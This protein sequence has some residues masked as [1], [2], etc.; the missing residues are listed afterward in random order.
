MFLWSEFLIGLERLFARHLVM[1][2]L[3]N[4]FPRNGEARLSVYI[5]RLIKQVL[6]WG[7]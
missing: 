3:A 2:S 5:E 1:L 6:S 4:R 7:L